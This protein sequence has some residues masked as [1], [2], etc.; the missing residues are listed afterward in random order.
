MEYVNFKGAKRRFYD[1]CVRKK[2]LQYRVQGVYKRLKK[3]YV[4]VMSLLIVTEKYKTDIKTEYI[5]IELET[6]STL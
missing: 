3:W 2:C 5:F 1:F 4:V 6:E